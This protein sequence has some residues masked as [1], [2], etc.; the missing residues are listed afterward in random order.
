MDGKKI[1]VVGCGDLGSQ[2]AQ[3]LTEFGAKVFGARR[4]PI[5]L[6]RSVTPVYLDVSKP[7][8]WRSINFRPHYVVFAASPVIKTPET[9]QSVICEG[10]SNM[11][12]WLRA[13]NHQPAH[14]V[15]ASHISVYGQNHGEW[16]DESSDTRGCSDKGAV[17][18]AAEELLRNS[19]FSHTS[20]RF[21]EIYTAGR[22]RL[23]RQVLA[24]RSAPAMVP[25]FINRIHLDDAAG[26]VAHLLDQV[27]RGN[28]VD[29]VYVASSQHAP[30]L[31]Y[32]TK[33]LARTMAVDIDDD[34]SVLINE[35]RKLGSL[36]CDVSRM[37]E[38]GYQLIYSDLEAGFGAMIKAL[39]CLQ[40]RRLAMT[41]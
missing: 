34:S 4:N 22:D 16:V 21:A 7:D 39:P 33:W 38:T 40:Q 23:I 1:L 8:A 18:L 9:L 20:I 14:I 11:L 35:Q 15:F 13:A 31:H 30:N 26:F 17:L 29:Q 41:A 6:S 32:F 10:V 2:V 5:A 27:D 36:R 25:H 19:E 28:D 24:G 12:D 37:E 3:R